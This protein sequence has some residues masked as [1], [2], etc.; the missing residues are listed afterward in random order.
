[1]LKK[2]SEKLSAKISATTRGYSGVKNIARLDDPFL[3]V[4]FNPKQAQ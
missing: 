4:L 3:K 1:M 2:L